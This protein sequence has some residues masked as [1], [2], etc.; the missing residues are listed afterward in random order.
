MCIAL[1]PVMKGCD[2]GKSH[3]GGVVQ[4]LGQDR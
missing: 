2:L 4:L 3:D 1:H